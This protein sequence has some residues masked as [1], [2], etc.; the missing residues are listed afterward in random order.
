MLQCGAYEAY[1]ITGF[2]SD[3][4]GTPTNNAVKSRRKD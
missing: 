3:S 1:Y 2:D 4:Y